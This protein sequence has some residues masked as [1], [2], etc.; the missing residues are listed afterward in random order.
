MGARLRASGLPPL[1]LLLQLLALLLLARAQQPPQQQTADAPPPPPPPRRSA[2]L[3]ADLAGSKRDLKRLLDTAVHI[4][5]EAGPNHYPRAE[6]CLKEAI[7][8]FCPEKV[9]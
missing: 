2:P 8:N 5:Q 3:C 7:A 1:L 9:T 4:Q 6:A